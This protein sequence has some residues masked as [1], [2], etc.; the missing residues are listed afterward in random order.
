VKTYSRSV[1]EATR[2]ALSEAQAYA[3]LTFSATSSAA[4]GAR[5]RRNTSRNDATAPPPTSPRTYG[6]GA[7]CRTAAKPSIEK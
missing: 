5:D 2:S 3:V 4:V 6:A 1:E 7:A